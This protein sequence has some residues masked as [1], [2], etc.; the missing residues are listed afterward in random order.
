MKEKVTLMITEEMRLLLAMSNCMLDDFEGA[1]LRR[2][3][4]GAGL[5]VLWSWAKG[6]KGIGE[7]EK[8]IIW[9]W[10]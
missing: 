3:T 9:K 10:G 4:E 5:W 7:I 2:W 1:G 6:R 8:E